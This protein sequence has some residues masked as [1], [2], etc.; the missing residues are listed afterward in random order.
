MTESTTNWLQFLQQQGA[1]IADAS[2]A[3]VLG[4]GT[5][6]IIPI[7]TADFVAPLTDLGLI[8]LSGEDATHFLHNQL[9]NDVEHLGLTEARLAG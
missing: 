2:R 9:T 8:A 1:H 6:S 4:S 3:E 7:P 5:D